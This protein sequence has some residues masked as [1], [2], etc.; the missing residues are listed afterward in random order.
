MKKN[1]F[2]WQWLLYLWVAP[3]TALCLPLALL[4]KLTGG[5]YNLHTGVLEIWGG[6]VGNRLN[7][8]IPFLGS[9]NAI[10]LGHIVAG[11]SPEHLRN[12]R[13]HERVH[14]AQFERWGFLFPLV[15]LLAGIKARQ[16]GGSLYWDNPYEIEA[17][18]KAAEAKDNHYT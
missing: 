7:R 10:T 5:G 18:T 2:W 1:S 11:I 9:V 12:S 3:I 8:G 4:A 6:W 13:I 15:Y 17:Y 16:R 14:V